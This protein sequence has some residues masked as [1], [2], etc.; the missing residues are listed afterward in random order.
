MEGGR[1]GLKKGSCPASLPC[2]CL[3]WSPW[4]S[5]T[6][7]KKRDQEGVYQCPQAEMGKLRSGQRDPGPWGHQESTGSPPSELLT[8]II[9]RTGAKDQ[10]EEEQT[11]PSVV[12]G[13]LGPV[14]ESSLSGFPLSSP[15]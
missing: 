8:E 12:R 13:D 15:K 2:F 7:V 1:A 9:G 5:K 11:A 10:E 6:C 4:K 3:T 14:L